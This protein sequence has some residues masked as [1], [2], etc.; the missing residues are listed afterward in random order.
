MQGSTQS[1]PHPRH[2]TPGIPSDL[3]SFALPWLAPF[4]PRFLEDTSMISPSGPLHLLL[5]LHGELSPTLPLYPH[6][7]F[8]HLLQVAAIASPSLWGLPDHLAQP[9][10]S[11]CPL[12]MLCSF[13]QSSFPSNI[14]FILL[15]TYSC[16]FC[17]MLPH[18]QSLKQCL[19]HRRCLG[20]I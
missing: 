1:V 19:A 7:S 20:N 17:S 15:H 4:Q 16:L 14:P 10:P 18:P 3:I 5:P 2:P 12:S 6:G 13:P 11:S 8:S 9:S